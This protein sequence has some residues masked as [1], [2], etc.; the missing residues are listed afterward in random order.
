MPYASPAQRRKYH[1]M[2]SREE[3]RRDSE[4]LVTPRR[5]TLFKEGRMDENETD[6]KLVKYEP[7][8]VTSGEPHTNDFDD[9]DHP[10]EFYE[11]GRVGDDSDDRDL[12]DEEEDHSLKTPER[13]EVDMEFVKALRRRRSM[14]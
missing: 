12:I 3:S 10:M 8:K 9:D 4:D 13:G 11:G 1:E 6:P 5:P 14:A 2:L 7:T